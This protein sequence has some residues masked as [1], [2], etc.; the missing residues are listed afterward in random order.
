M[1]YYVIAD[2]DTVLG[3]SLVGLSGQ[4]VHNGDEA[5][6]AWS[7]ALEDDQNAV[8]II[9]ESVADMIRGTVDRYL[10]S[11]SFPLVV[12]IPDPGKKSSRDLRRLVNEAV[13][14]SI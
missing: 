5:R 10:F 7:R 9:T 13:G 8:I 3:F 12:E 4:A 1:K 14:V 2:E 6:D 11:E